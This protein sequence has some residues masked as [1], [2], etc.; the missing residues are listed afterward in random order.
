MNEVKLL[1]IG[2]V[3][4]N[5]KDQYARDVIAP[6]ENGLDSSTNLPV[7]S[8]DYNEGEYLIGQDRQYYITLTDI[9]VGDTL[10]IGTN[11]RRT[12]VSEEIIAL[13]NQSADKVIEIIADEEDGSTAS[14]DYSVGKYIYWSYGLTAGLYEVTLDI[15][16]GDALVEGTNIRV[17][18][19]VCDDILKLK[20]DVESIYNTNCNPNLFI[21]PWFEINQRELSYYTGNNVSGVYTTDRWKINQFANI[22]VSSTGI[23]LGC[24][25][26]A[27]ASPSNYYYMYTMFEKS[28]LEEYINKKITMSVL[29]NDGSVY[30]ASFTM[31]NYPDS[32][33]VKIFEAEITNGFMMNAYL[34]P[35]YS[36][37][38]VFHLINDSDNPTISIRAIKLETG[39]VSTLKNEVSPEYTSELKKCQRYFYRISN[40][41]PRYSAPLTMG[42]IEQFT[43]PLRNDCFMSIELANNM[44]TI[45]SI[46][47]SN[48]SLSKNPINASA[49]IPVSNILGYNTFDDN[50]RRTIQVRPSDA[51][52]IDTSSAYWLVINPNGYLEFT[53]EL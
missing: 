32:G 2:G 25:E 15:V 31:P 45:P 39:D 18:N 10:V 7:S 48:V 17:A 1:N 29:L 23:I 34:Y 16:S 8:R 24:N 6:S 38:E 11:I 19:K 53:S 20:G 33:N 37:F 43:N 14:K 30:S 51:S 12:T 5:I 36:L 4:Q 22:T 26:G 9:E 13:K 28:Y 52:Q 40:T 46:R 49:A 3:D 41:N 50:R 47:Y 44:R 35:S 21:N 42:T 27:E